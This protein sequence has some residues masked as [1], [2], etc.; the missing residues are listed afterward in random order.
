MTLRWTA[1]EY[2]LL[3]EASLV[4]DRPRTQIVKRAALAWLGQQAPRR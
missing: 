1:E 2:A 3:T 4:E